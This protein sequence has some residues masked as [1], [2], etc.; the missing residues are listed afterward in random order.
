[1]MASGIHGRVAGVA[2]KVVTVEIAR[3]V[4]VEV[5]RSSIQTVTKGPALEGRGKERERA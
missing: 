5:D 1:V 4:Q 2:E 3:N